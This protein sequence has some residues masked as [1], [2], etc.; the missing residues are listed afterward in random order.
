MCLSCGGGEMYIQTVFLYPL[1]TFL[2][3]LDNQCVANQKWNQNDF[4]VEGQVSTVFSLPIHTVHQANRL[5]PIFIIYLHGITTVID[6]ISLENVIRI[7]RK[8]WWCMETRA[9]KCQE[10]LKVEQSSYMRTRIST[11]SLVI[12]LGHRPCMWFHLH[13]LASI[14][15]GAMTASV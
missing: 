5:G 12:I 2:I 13:L 1:A 14:T 7:S 4:L 15:H 11:C 8:F 9:F 3:P 6:Y 10:E